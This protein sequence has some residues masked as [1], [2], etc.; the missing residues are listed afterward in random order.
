MEICSAVDGW[1]NFLF[2]GSG[3]SLPYTPQSQR[4]AYPGPRPVVDRLT[5]LVRN[6]K[7]TKKSRVCVVY[8]KDYGFLH[9]R[10]RSELYRSMC[11]RL[12]LAKGLRLWCAYI[13]HERCTR[14]L[15]LFVIG[16]IT[17]QLL[18]ETVFDRQ[19]V[20][21]HTALLHQETQNVTETF[22]IKALSVCRSR[23]NYE[24]NIDSLNLRGAACGTDCRAE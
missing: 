14:V 11:S 3:Q 16:R 9:P 20:V 17:A 5:T 1:I 6:A 19:R 23:H 10:L 8:N 18:F 4:C 7:R 2:A 21:H 12:P 13:H 15:R 22:R 24:V